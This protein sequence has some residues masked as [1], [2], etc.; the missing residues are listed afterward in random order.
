MGWGNKNSAE[1]G[2]LGGFIAQQLRALPTL[3]DDP[4]PT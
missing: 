3:P 4:A 1:F 2:I